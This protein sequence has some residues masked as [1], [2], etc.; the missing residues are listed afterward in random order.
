[1]PSTRR[2]VVSLMLA[3]SCLPTAAHAAQRTFVATTG[4]D[5]PNCAVTAPCRT[6][7]AAITATTSGGEIVVLDSGG[8]GPVTIGKSVSIIAPPGVY[9][10]VS[11]SSGDGI[12]VAGAGIVVVLRGLS[13]NGVG[14][15]NGIAIAS[16]ATVRIEGCVVSNMGAAGILHNDGKLY[17]EDTTVRNNAGIGIWSSGDT[18]Q[19]DLDRARVEQNADG[20]RAQNGAETV[21]HDSVVSRNSSVGVFAYVTD[22]SHQTYTIVTVSRSLVSRNNVGVQSHGAGSG[23]AYASVSDSTIER[24]TLN[25]LLATQASNGPST[26]YIRR[27]MIYDTATGSDVHVSVGAFGVFDDNWM[28]SLLVDS[29]ANADSRSNN[30][31]LSF[32]CIAPG[33]LPSW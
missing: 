2:T 8:Y 15:S 7:A 19:A 21:V 33:H 6:F 13:V 3:A 17:V 1:M 4:S 23:G 27:N 31:T 20:V 25:G 14:G 12:T 30:T 28:G 24:N 29:G 11:V 22:T 18:A 9:A 32:C 5:N 10:G 16:A 26:L